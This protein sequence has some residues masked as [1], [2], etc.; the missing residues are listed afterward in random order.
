MAGG[1][2]LTMMNSGS[3]VA[4][5]SFGISMSKIWVQMTEAKDGYAQYQPATR[6]NTE[7]GTLR[8]SQSWRPWSP[9]GISHPNKG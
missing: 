4:C 2:A 5:V 3:L 6:K 1:S 8:N 7:V 9:G